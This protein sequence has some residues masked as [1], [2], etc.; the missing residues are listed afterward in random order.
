MKFFFFYFAYISFVCRKAHQKQ[1]SQI[2][3]QLQYWDIFFLRNLIIFNNHSALFRTVPLQPVMPTLEE[4]L[5]VLP[6]CMSG[7]VPA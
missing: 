7:V 5:V 1:I 2:K 6:G 3:L 4:I